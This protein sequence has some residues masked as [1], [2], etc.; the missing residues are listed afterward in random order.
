MGGQK[1]IVKRSKGWIDIRLARK[2]I[3]CGSGDAMSAQRFYQRIL[4]DHGAARGIDQV[5]RGLHQRDHFPRNHAFGLGCV[6]TVKGDEIAVFH[7]GLQRYARIAQLVAFRLG[8]TGGIQ[9]AHAHQ[10]GKIRYPAADAAHAHH[11]QHG[12]VQR[13]AHAASHAE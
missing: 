13:G 3:Q 11:A 1:H 4:I 10:M 8:G 12:P 7:Q 5:S 6:G 2:H 9:H